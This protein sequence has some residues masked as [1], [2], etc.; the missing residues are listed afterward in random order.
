MARIFVLDDH[1]M[2]CIIVTRLLQQA[3]H[4]VRHGQHSSALFQALTEWQPDLV[5]LDL[6]L[7]Q[8]D[9]RAVIRRLRSLSSIPI[10]MLTA[11]NDVQ[12]KVQS[13]DI[14]ADDYLSKPFAHEELLARI[15]ALLRRAAMPPPEPAP[16]RTGLTLDCDLRLL[17][18]ADVGALSLTEAE[19]RL[20]EAL[21]AQSGR[22]LSR[23]A[24]FKAV[25]RRNWTPG[26]RSL[27][28]HISNLRRKLDQFAPQRVQIQSLRGVGYRLL[29]N[30]AADD[31]DTG[32]T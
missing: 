5:I 30:E 15:R 27:D 23:E 10:L 1:L 31:N 13:L 16:R 14:G 32:K 22:P 28:V 6:E 29:V 3:H 4:E 24:L 11:R 17:T 2:M 19:C 25:L 18:L 8:E 7:A 12:S 9:G 20:F 26:E 21:L